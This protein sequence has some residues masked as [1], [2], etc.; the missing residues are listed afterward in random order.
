ML[1]GSILCPLGKKK[2]CLCPR[3]YSTER[4]DFIQTEQSRKVLESMFFLG[5][6]YMD[7][8]FEAKFDLILSIGVLEWVGAFRK[9]IN[10]LKKFKEFL[11]KIRTDLVDGGK[12]IIGIENRLGLKYLMGA[13]DDHT[14]IPNICF[15]KDLARKFKQ[16]TN[17]ELKCITY[18]LKEYRNLLLK[19]GFRKLSSMLPFPIINYPRKFSHCPGPNKM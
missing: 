2:S 5:V 10:R 6:D 12:L 4:L 7:V 1:V 18:N 13:N 8:H 9:V 17:K 19:S 16:Q 14:G 11:S 15:S 3:T